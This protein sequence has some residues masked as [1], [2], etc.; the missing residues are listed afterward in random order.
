MSSNGWIVKDSEG[1][2]LGENPAQKTESV[3]NM[4]NNI[5]CW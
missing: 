1:Q 4:P 3:E 2:I 5:Y